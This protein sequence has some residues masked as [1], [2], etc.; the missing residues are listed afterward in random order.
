MLSRTL[1]SQ[2]YEDEDEEE[3]PWTSD[4]LWLHNQYRSQLALGHLADFPATG[5]RFEMRWDNQLAEVV[6]ALAERCSTPEGVVS[7]DRPEE[8]T[9]L[10]FLKVGQN[11][12]IQRAAFTAKV[13][14]KCYFFVQDLFDENYLYSS[15]KGE[16]YEA[17]DGA[18]YVTQIAWARFYAVSCGFT[19][20]FLYPNPQKANYPKDGAF[21]M[22]I[23]VCNYAPAGNVIDQELY[24]PGTPC[25]FSPEDTE[26]KKMTG[27]CRVTGLEPA[28]DKTTTTT[29]K[30]APTTTAPDDHPPSDSAPETVAVMPALAGALTAVGA[31]RRAVA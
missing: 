12:F 20:D 8:R 11:L 25:S 30:K 23:Y 6:Q 16:K 28:D 15:S 17:M 4:I 2:E 24:W 3:S 18:K 22:S 29:T 5:N 31:S 26:S 19:Y 13:A 7:H 9:T 27:N 1:C 10:T 14:V 21:R